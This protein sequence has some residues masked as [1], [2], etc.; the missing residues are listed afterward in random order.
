MKALHSLKIVPFKNRS[1]S[2]SYRLTGTV[3][4][5]RVRINFPSR[6]EAVAEFDHR[7]RDLQSSAMSAVLT[8]LP[9]ERVREAEFAGKRL[10]SG[11]T[12]LQAADFF[13]EHY[14]PLVPLSWAESIELFQAHLV[15]ERKTL[16]ATADDRAGELRQF[17]RFIE[18]R[19]IDRTDRLRPE[20]AKAWIY[21]ADLEA[22]SQR[23]RYDRL[24]QFCDWLV[25]E[26]HATINPVAELIRPKVRVDPPA[27]F[28]PE[29]IK[30]LLDAAWT[31]PEGP[32]MLPHFAICT[33]CGVRPGECVQ[34][35]SGDIFLEGPHP[36]IEVNKAKGGRSR[37]NVE[38]SDQL[39][40]ILRRC[41]ELR[42]APGFFSVR[43][44]N[45]IRR[46]AGLFE[47]WEKDIERHTFASYHY[48]L[49]RDIDAL[50]KTMGNSAKVLFTS[51]I[52]AVP[53]ADAV[54]TAAIAADWAA[55]RRQSLEGRR[56]DLWAKMDPKLLTP[57]QRAAVE[58]W[59]Q[60]QHAPGGGP[61][62]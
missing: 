54:K 6:P 48:E 35:R 56:A 28:T 11:T 45:R 40:A 12:L 34:L 31:D 23:D 53:H 58:R 3:L 13:R 29:Q 57:L 42:L 59:R 51:Y 49:H 2:I 17:S 50:V 25:R 47:L 4:G 44:F 26:K 16:E 22:R 14:R 5:E 27:I 24:N 18:K 15:A 19:R 52:R 1:R 46:D 21:A 39:A 62:A 60:R 38:V 9:E 32:E 41:K 55:P 43:K 61:G 36:V 8:S 20:D 7:T 33:L 10:P 37:R 30:A